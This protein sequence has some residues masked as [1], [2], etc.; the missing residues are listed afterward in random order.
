VQEQVELPPD[1]AIPLVSEEE[2]DAETVLVV[3]GA[4]VAVAPS[5]NAASSEIQIA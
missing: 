4:P 2:T 5:I 1:V 3:S